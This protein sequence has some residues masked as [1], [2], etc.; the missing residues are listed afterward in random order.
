MT[1]VTNEAAGFSLKKLLCY[2]HLCF[3][4]LPLPSVCVEFCGMF[5][6]IMCFW[7]VAAV[8][9][10]RTAIQCV[11]KMS[12]RNSTD[13]SDPLHSWLLFA[14]QALRLLTL[15][16]ERKRRA[17]LGSFWPLEGKKCFQRS[18]SSLFWYRIW[19]WS[20]CFQR[21]GCIVSLP[22]QAPADSE[23]RVRQNI[24]QPGLPLAC[25]DV[26]SGPAFCVG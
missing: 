14:K 3:I 20:K 6:S 2:L 5:I 21:T 13:S 1:V 17:G 4:C 7:W 12:V 18:V 10:G 24:A 9:Y 15:G 11:P 23:Q 19:L 16:V 22:P 25:E 8:W 26:A